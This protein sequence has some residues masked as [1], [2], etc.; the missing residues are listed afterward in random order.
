MQIRQEKWHTERSKMGASTIV[1]CLSLTARIAKDVQWHKD[2]LS[3][4]THPHITP[5]PSLWD[6]RLASGLAIGLQFSTKKRWTND[7]PKRYSTSNMTGRRFHRT[8]EAIPRCPWKSK[9]P[10]AS[11]PMKISIQRGRE[12]CAVPVVQSYRSPRYAK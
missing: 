4:P 3:F 10:F 1:R 6:Y 12:G 9:S 11:R 5:M 8:T 7:G 2:N